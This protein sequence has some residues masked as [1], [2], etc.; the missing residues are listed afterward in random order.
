MH[1]SC[2]KKF[3]LLYCNLIFTEKWHKSIIQ[4]RTIPTEYISIYFISNKIFQKSH[5]KHY[6]VS[7]IFYP[8]SIFY[9]IDP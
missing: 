3:Q 5:P 8:Q 6:I 4:T 9:K 1:N 7:N 2:L